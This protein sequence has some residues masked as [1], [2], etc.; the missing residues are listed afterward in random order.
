MIRG[1][2]PLVFAVAALALTAA[3]T[4]AA[5]VE[6][7]HFSDSFTVEVERCGITWTAAVTSE[8]VRLVKSTGETTPPSVIHNY[9]NV[10][11]WTDVNDPDRSYQV[12]LQ[13]MI[14]EQAIEYLGGT[15]YLY[16]AAEIG[17]PFTVRTLDGR[18]VMHDRGRLVYRYVIDTQGNADPSD[19]EYIED[20]GLVGMTGKFPSFDFTGAE[21]CAIF[22]EAAEG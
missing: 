1:L 12:V 15:R 19:D 5:P 7:E 2:R 21:L 10:I 8:G 4:L 22:A 18:I 3:P 9:R 6:Q 13:G 20:A 17:Q 16:E 11:V 14:R